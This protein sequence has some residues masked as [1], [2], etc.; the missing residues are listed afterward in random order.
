MTG[1][2]TP[3][4]I[5][6]NQPSVDEMDM[7]KKSS[8]VFFILSFIIHAVVFFGM[9]YFQNFTFPKPMPPVIQVDLVSFSPDLLDS[10]SGSNAA[11]DEKA[12]PP[13]A[14]IIKNTPEKIKH[15]KADVSLKTKPK[16]IKELME[17]QKQNETKPEK[18]KEKESVKEP[19]KELVKAPEKD[20]DAQ[21]EL[22]KARQDLEKKIEDQ[23]N[24][25]IA[26]ALRRLKS[27][28]QGQGKEKDGQVENSF[29]G[30]GQKGYKP[31]D[32]YKLVLGSTIKQNWVYSDVLAGMDQNL[33]VRILIKILRSG[34]IRDIIYETKSGNRYLDE[35]AKNTIKKSNPLPPL[36]A[37]MPSF[38]VLVIFTPQG[39]R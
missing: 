30:K 26:E 5:Q 7:N 10:S 36:P 13:K 32:L 9:V 24:E 31:L 38:D 25:R 29:A 28:V 27:S 34:E 1:M 8:I 12:A 11:S 19:E 17:K 14:Q 15:I 6:D 37:G 23:N 21:K 35:S 3:G 39:L 33:E 2:Q 4:S 18:K 20:V 16:N 22:E